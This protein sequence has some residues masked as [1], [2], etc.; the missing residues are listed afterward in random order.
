MVGSCA[1]SVPPT[2]DFT[3]Q[4]LKMMQLWY[5]RMPNMGNEPREQKLKKSRPELERSEMVKPNTSSLTDTVMT[6]LQ[7]DKEFRDEFIEEEAASDFAAAIIELR[8]KR[9]LTQAELA[10]LAGMKQSAISRLERA[11]YSKWSFATI[12]RIA[13]ALRARIDFKFEEI[14]E[15]YRSNVVRSSSYRSEKSAIRAWGHIP[16]ESFSSSDTMK[17]YRA[18]I[19]P[20]KKIEIE[21]WLVYAQVGEKSSSELAVLSNSSNASHSTVYDNLILNIERNPAQ[22]VDK[23]A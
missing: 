17:T 22:K 23:I 21:N 1:C 14:E 15:V 12:V 18:K 2:S 13:Q 16:S 10:N 9:G 11:S 4:S 7:T 8:R 5:S 19:K 6:L 3:S 20:K